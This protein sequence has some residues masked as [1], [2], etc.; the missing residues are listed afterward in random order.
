M[1]LNGQQIFEHMADIPDDLI[2][3]SLPAVG[4]GTRGAAKRVRR[5]GRA[6]AFFRSGWFAAILCAVVSLSVL[7]I[8]IRAGQGGS[9]TPSGAAS[10]GTKNDGVMTENEMS[11]EPDLKLPENVEVETEAETTDEA[12]AETTDEAGYRQKV[13]VTAR[14]CNGQKYDIVYYIEQNASR[15][16]DSELNGYPSGVVGMIYSSYDVTFV[17]PSNPGAIFTDSIDLGIDPLTFFYLQDAL[18]FANTLADAVVHVEYDIT[19]RLCKACGETAPIDVAMTYNSA[20]V[21]TRNCQGNVCMVPLTL[22]FVNTLQHS[23]RMYE[24]R[25]S[26]SSNLGIVFR[27]IDL[28]TSVYWGLSTYDRTDLSIYLKNAFSQATVHADYDET[29]HICAACGQL[30]GNKKDLPA[31][32]SVQSIKIT[33]CGNVD[34]T[35]TVT[36]PTVISKVLTFISEAGG[37]M[38]ESTMGHYGTVFRIDIVDKDGTMSYTFNLW[39]SKRYSIPQYKD[40]DGY[41]YFFDADM[42]DMYE[43]LNEKYPTEFW[44]PDGTT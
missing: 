3:D 17:Q 36:D 19:Q 31:M 25:F 10:V 28:T 14:D 1:K 30:V 8:V 12:E 29:S 41:E 4:S 13:T 9:P 40:A 21:A 27:G 20:V 38:G 22:H 42:S 44:Y 32:D 15:V 6:S 23:S 35:L 16:T 7:G 37:Q 26:F 24:V 18:D 34:K 33:Y 39:D 43:Y 5:E 2:L 11:L